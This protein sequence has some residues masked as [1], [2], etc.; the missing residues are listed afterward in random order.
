MNILFL[1]KVYEVGGQEVVTAT[2]AKSFV[3]HGHHV[4]IASFQPPN[5]MMVKRTDGRIQFYTIGTFEYNKSNVSTL[6]SILLKEKIGI[7]INQWGLPYVP[8]KVA[9]AASKDSKVKIISVYHNNPATNARIQSCD[10]ALAESQNVLSKI[11]ISIKRLAFRFITSRS[12]RYVYEHSDIYMVLSPSFIEPFCHF[13]NIKDRSKLMVQTNPVTM[14]TPCEALDDSV[15]RKEVV[16]VGRIDCNQKRIERIIT[17]WSKIE[18]T[19]QDWVLT[20]V[21]DGPDR[22]KMEELVEK[23][24]IKNISFEGFKNPTEYYKRASLLLLTSDFE[25]FPLV[26][27][28]CMSFGVVPIV[29]GSYSA[30]YDIIKDKENGRIL[31]P[32]NGQFIAEDMANILSEVMTDSDNRDR[33]AIN[34]IETSKGY[35]IDL[36]YEQWNICFQKLVN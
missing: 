23:L 22:P 35:S 15:K 13:T 9:R 19:H 21:G 14:E 28:E 18:S 5:D 2:L 3:E 24:S 7:I 36:I 25:G 32:K 10:S 6:C 33:I 4:V 17:M 26:L 30:V 27:A 20:I 8:I 1:M 34:A 31:P 12:M 29:Y 16:Y 11:F